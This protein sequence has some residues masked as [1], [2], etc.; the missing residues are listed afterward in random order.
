MGIKTYPW[1][2]AEFLTTPEAISSYLEVVLEDDEMP[3]RMRALATIARAR[4]GMDIVAAE[5][6]ISVEILAKAAQEVG[7]GDRNTVVKVMES[8]RRRVSSDSLT[9]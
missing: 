7:S 6:G 2:A 8:Y 5:T 4:G 9:S 1:D 3:Y